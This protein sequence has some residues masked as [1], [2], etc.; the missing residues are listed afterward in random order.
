MRPLL[1]LVTGT[2]AFAEDE[3]AAAAPAKRWFAER[4]TAL[5]GARRWCG[6]DRCDLLG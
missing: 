2:I 3:A 5:I 1:L 6:I 4:Y